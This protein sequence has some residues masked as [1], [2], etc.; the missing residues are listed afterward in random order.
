MFL[1]QDR[2]YLI[3]AQSFSL[4]ATGLKVRFSIARWETIPLNYL[5]KCTFDLAP[6]F[7]LINTI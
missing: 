2:L 4:S 1:D 5:W 3:L 7:R 6:E